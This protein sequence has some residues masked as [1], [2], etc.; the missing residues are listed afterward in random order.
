MW[1]TDNELSR[2]E[3]LRRSLYR[4]LRNELDYSLIQFGLIDP[5]FKFQKA[6][7]DYKFVV[8]RELKPR[9]K[10]TEMESDLIDGFIILFTESA[11]PAELKKYIR[12]FDNNKVTKENLPEMVLSSSRVAPDFLKSQKAFEHTKFLHLLK[13]LL[14]VDYSLLIQ[15]DNSSKKNRYLL[16][17]FHVRIDWLI[18]FA[19]ESLGKQ[20]RY[21]SKDLYEK[22]EKHAENLVE[23]LFEY[24]TFHHTASG[25]RTAAIVACQLLTAADFISTV[26]V[27]SAESR[28][29][30]R[31]SEESVSKFCLVK[32]SKEHME[33]IEASEK[34]DIKNFRK[35]YL[36][37]DG[38]DYGVGIFRVVYTHNKSSS[39]PADGKLRELQSDVQWVKISEQHLLPKPAAGHQR[40]LN[41]SIIYDQQDPFSR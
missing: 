19:A 5:Y 2:S 12:Y 6:G 17:H 39:P 18:D 30:T 16:S 13:T 7:T 23:K 21:I 27:N 8:K 4:T 9:A 14:P 25:R 33:T 24:F 28:T 20:L 32:L 11:V 36:I 34:L 41:Y 22:G 3:K 35:D 31:I 37:H 15:Q 38:G 40:P 26:Y 29:L 10:V 1:R